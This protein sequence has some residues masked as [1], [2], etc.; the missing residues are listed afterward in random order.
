MASAAQSR[1]VR[2]D[3]SGDDQVI[4]IPQE[5]ELQGDEA[6]IT[7]DA[8][9]RLIVS[10]SEEIINARRH[11]KLLTLTELMDSWEP[12]GEEDAMPEIED[13]PPEPVEL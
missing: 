7:Q 12:L 10:P 8:D 2:I 11:A 5:F 13:L 1:S 9:G 6:T 4:R 3:R